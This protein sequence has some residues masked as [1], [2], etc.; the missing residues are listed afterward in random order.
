MD[1]GIPQYWQVRLAL[2]G[3]PSAF[4]RHLLSTL[5]AQHGEWPTPAPW[6]DTVTQHASDDEREM[7]KDF[8]ADHGG[9]LPTEN[10]WEQ[11]VLAYAV[12][13]D[14]TEVRWVRRTEDNPT[15]YAVERSPALQAMWGPAVRKE[16]G[17]GVENGST[18][19]VTEDAI[20]EGG[21]QECQHTLVLKRKRS[22]EL[23]ARS[24]MHLRLRLRS[25]AQP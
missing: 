11:L 15:M 21:Y 4:H 9:R 5:K 19:F 13:G 18:P 20:R 7:I 12:V 14:P 8:Q 3:R 2:V 6:A 24:A 25:L 23:H 16:I 17:G 1:D 22:G 10:E